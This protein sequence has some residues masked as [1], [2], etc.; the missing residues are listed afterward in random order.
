MLKECYYLEGS[1]RDLI[2]LLNSYKKMIDIY[3]S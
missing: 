3:D 1:I 2:I